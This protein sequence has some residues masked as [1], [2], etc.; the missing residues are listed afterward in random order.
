MRER[1]N[2]HGIS[3]FQ[4]A[5]VMTANHASAFGI[6]A[7]IVAAFAGFPPLILPAIAHARASLS[8][9][10][11]PL[12]HC[13]TPA[14]E[15]PA[16]TP[17]P[18]RSPTA[19]K[20]LT[21]QGG[22]KHPL[23]GGPL[24]SL[25]CPSRPLCTKAVTFVAQATCQTPAKM[26]I[27]TRQIQIGAEYSDPPWI[28]TLRQIKGKQSEQKKT[29]DSSHVWITFGICGGGERRRNRV[30]RGDRASRRGGREWYGSHRR[31]VRA[32]EV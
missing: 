15:K 3:N 9:A 5:V 28:R 10:S 13:L 19:K 12:F 14:P 22:M 30:E 18:V 17:K 26:L 20:R 23:E 16:Y 31:G 21:S 29:L 24:F 32:R 4:N 8:Q 6:A 1:G 11:T 27:H 2:A 7:V 25:T